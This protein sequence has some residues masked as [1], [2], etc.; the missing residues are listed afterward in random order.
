[1]KLKK[2]IYKLCVIESVSDFV[3]YVY[4]FLI[5]NFFSFRPVVTIQALSRCHS[6]CPVNSNVLFSKDKRMDTQRVVKE[7]LIVCKEGK[8]A[9]YFRV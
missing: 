6:G 8:T 5:K 1:M 4:L 9:R 3:T 2:D 7:T